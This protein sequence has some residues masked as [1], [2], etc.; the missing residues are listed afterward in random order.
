MATSC[1][2]VK[3]PR[4]GS[5]AASRRDG[6]R[7]VGCFGVLVLACVTAASAAPLTVVGTCRQGRKVSKQTMPIMMAMR[8]RGGGRTTK[9][10]VKRPR[11]SERGPGD[12]EE[13]SSSS[14]DPEWEGDQHPKVRGPKRTRFALYCA[15]IVFVLG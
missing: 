2:D 13:D 10:G 3:E 6:T 15:S 12:V 4:E 1:S 5:A 11:V 9:K 14:R 7:W 8:L